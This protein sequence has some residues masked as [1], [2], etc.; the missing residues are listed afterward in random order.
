MVRCPV[1]GTLLHSPP[2]AEAMLQ[3]LLVF[4][5][6]PRP[7]LQDTNTCLLCC[8]LLSNV[9]LRWNKTCALR[10]RKPMESDMQVS[11]TYQDEWKGLLYPLTPFL[12][13]F[14]R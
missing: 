13:P 14:L 5:P 7:Q 9:H 12:P 4:L 3:Q 11:H 10:A 1:P 2:H 8:E 6:Q